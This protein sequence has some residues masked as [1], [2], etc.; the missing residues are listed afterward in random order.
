MDIERACRT[1]PLASAALT[2]TADRPHLH[3]TNQP[4]T[5]F[6]E[7]LVRALRADADSTIPGSLLSIAEGGTDPFTSTA[8]LVDGLTA[9]NRPG[10]SAGALAMAKLAGNSRRRRGVRRDTADRGHLLPRWLVELH[11]A[12]PVVRAV[13][14]STAFRDFALPR[15]ARHGFAAGTAARGHP[16]G[17]AERGLRPR[18]SDDA[19]SAVDRYAG[20]YLAAVHTFADDVAWREA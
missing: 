1:G 2:D 14:L 11:G 15:P 6:T 3:I 9:S 20:P 16:C 13:E 8:T 18:L 10:C 5:K 7:D 19:L 12:E 4:R 17:H